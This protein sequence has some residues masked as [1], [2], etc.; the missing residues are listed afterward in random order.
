M[1]E[2]ILEKI[3]NNYKL[4]GEEKDLLIKIL[5]QDFDE[6]RVIFVTDFIIEFKLDFNVCIAYLIYEVWKRNDKIADELL[7]CVN[8]DVTKMYNIFKT[9]RDITKITKSEEADDV[10]NMFIAICQDLRTI[11]VK[12]AMINYNMLKIRMPLSPKD[13]RMVKYVKEI[14]APLAERLGLNKLK[15]E[16][17]DLCLKYQEPEIYKEL[18]SNVLLKK[19]ENEKQ[20]A[21]TKLKLEKIMKELG[22]SNYEITYRQKHFSSIYKKIKEKNRSLGMIYDLIAMRV[23]CEKVEECYSVLGKIHS[24]YKPIDGRVKDYIANPKQNG[25]QSLHTT[26]IAENSRPLEIQIR[27]FSMHKIAEYGLAAHWMYKEKRTKQNALDAKLAWLRL[28]IDNSKNQS[29]KEFIE[30]LKINLY[31]GEIFVQTPKGKVIEFPEGACVI[32]FA[33]AIHSDVG[34]KCVGAKING[35]IVPITTELKTGDTVEI[36]TN[37]NSKGP[38][39]DWLKVIKTS[40]ARSK[41]KS[42][43]KEALKTENIKN[44]EAIL[45]E[46]LKVRGLSK[47]LLKQE[48]INKLLDKFELDSIEELYASIGQ[49]TLTANRVIGNLN[50]F[51]TQT[52]KF[53]PLNEE[54]IHL[55]KNADGVMVDGDTGMLVRY[56]GCCNPVVGDEIVGYISRGKGVTIHRKECCNLRYLEKERILPACFEEKVTRE[57]FADIKVI[58]DNENDVVAKITKLITDGGFVIRSL[59][60]SMQV[61][62]IKFEIVVGV[63]SK[64]DIEKLISQ[65]KSKKFTQNVY[66]VR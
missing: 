33:Y 19:E 43:F 56:A 61:D 48:F 38:S 10:R 58:T 14:Y 36:L 30:T 3:E 18:E 65:I 26:I 41:I 31:Q 52:K 32:D 39:R 4:K 13:A 63:R 8:A 60:T 53:E 51:Y 37:P 17:E 2:K 1:N 40:S 29:S 57:F 34:H 21:I 20:I 9:T 44:G 62:R 15:S 42:F 22:I 24:I 23:I 47:D 11:I 12:L 28:I 66:R 46:N 50:A 64:Q 16:L 5:T 6:E 27:T 59:N 54:K 7:I 45:L 35:K 55:H 25:Y 49:G